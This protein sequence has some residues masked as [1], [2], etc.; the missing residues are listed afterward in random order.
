M[1]RCLIHAGVNHIP[2]RPVST[3]TQDKCSVGFACAELGAVIS[4]EAELCGPSGDWE[5]LFVQE[6]LADLVFC[7]NSVKH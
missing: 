6:G 2:D 4:A 1:G 7:L 3:C 5:P